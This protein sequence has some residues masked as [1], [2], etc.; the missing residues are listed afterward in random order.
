MLLNFVA[1]WSQCRMCSFALQD[2]VSTSMSVF[3]V[4]SSCRECQLNVRWS[5]TGTHWFVIP[6]FCNFVTPLFHKRQAS[7][8]QIE[9]LTLVSEYF[10]SFFCRSM[11]PTQVTNCKNRVGQRNDRW[12]VSTECCNDELCLSL[13]LP[14]LCPRS[15]QWVSYRDGIKYDSSLK[16][17]QRNI[18]QDIC[19]FHSPI[20][21]LMKVYLFDRYTISDVLC[22]SM[23]SSCFQL[24]YFASIISWI[25]ILIEF[26]S[27]VPLAKLV[28]KVACTVSFQK[29]RK[30]CV[31]LQK[32]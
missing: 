21:M 31:R 6:S 19:S 20:K 12:Q 3:N 10:Y 32:H 17:L 8:F 25:I 13:T 24:F 11:H 2:R 27:L 5:F 23:L 18:T 26:E 30:S 15:I 4:E 9:N 22:P 14:N 16:L 29:R 28:A 1:K 7:E